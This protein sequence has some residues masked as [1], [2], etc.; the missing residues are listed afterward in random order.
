MEKEVVTATQHNMHHLF[1]KYS[2]EDETI[3]L[4]IKQTKKL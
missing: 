2:Y 4:N 1:T 3:V